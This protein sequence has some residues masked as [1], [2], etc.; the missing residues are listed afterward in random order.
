[1]QLLASIQAH[2]FMKRLKADGLGQVSF[3]ACFLSLAGSIDLR[4]GRQHQHGDMGGARLLGK[5]PHDV[6]AIQVIFGQ[7]PA[8]LFRAHVIRRN[9]RSE[10]ADHLI[11]EL[12]P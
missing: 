3:G 2:E 12:P 10:I 6:Q 1:M 7:H 5:R 11:I 9:L 4:S 8:Y